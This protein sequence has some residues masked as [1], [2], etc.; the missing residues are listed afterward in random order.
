[1]PF[2]KR[3]GVIHII[4]NTGRKN[5]SLLNESDVFH[6]H[7]GF[8]GK[9]QS[10][11]PSVVQQCSW[12]ASLVH[13]F[14]I[15]D[16]METSQLNTLLKTRNCKLIVPTHCAFNFNQLQFGVTNS[17]ILIHSHWPA[18]LKRQKEFSGSLMTYRQKVV[19]FFNFLFFYFLRTI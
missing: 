6:K 5:K 10:T 2:I 14:R 13:F 11:F 17:L 7:Q 12:I 1:M 15:P 9:C 4:S 18:L 16:F 3:V 8:Q 19:L